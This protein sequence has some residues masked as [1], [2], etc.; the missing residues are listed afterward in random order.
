M[1]KII[2]DGNSLTLE[3]IINV[4]RNYFEV[5]IDEASYE[6]IEYSRNIIEDI[7]HHEKVVYGVNTGFGSLANVS[8]SKEDTKQLQENLIRSHAAGFGNPL[9]TDVVRATMLIRVNSLIKGYS[10]IRRIVVDTIVDMLNKRVHP[11]IPEKG[12]L[13]A[14]G[15]LAP[16]SHMVL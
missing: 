4:S 15:D 6:K 10:G 16:L 11:I 3:D 13:G 1:N 2:I 12:S 9:D 14:S 5:E 8:V 7:I